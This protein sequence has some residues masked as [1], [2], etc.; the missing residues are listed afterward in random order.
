MQK[1]YKNILQE[2]TQKNNLKNP[3]YMTTSINIRSGLLWRAILVLFDGT[4]FESE[5]T[6]KKNAETNAAMLAC[7]YVNLLEQPKKV[8][9]TQKVNDILEIDL[10]CYR[11]I[12][13]VDAENLDI[14]M[15]NLPEYT[16]VLIFVSKNTSKKNVFQWQ[17]KYD[18]CYVFISDSVGPDASDHLLTFYA[19]KLSV[20]QHGKHQYYILTKDHFGA[21]IEK[22]MENCKFICSTNEIK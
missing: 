1:S 18:N 19:G 5:G 6:T 10:L 3:E 21:H 11:I 17:S 16:L 14:D 22:F 12:I 4:T 20:N 2:Y 15:D 9:C 7:N 8:L 13:L